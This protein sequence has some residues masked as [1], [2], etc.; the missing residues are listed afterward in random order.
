MSVIRLSFTITFLILALGWGFT[1]DRGYAG[2]IQTGYAEVDI[3]P[4]LGVTMPGYFTERRASDVLDP[5]L[6]KAMVMSDSET[7]LAIVALDLIGVPKDD[8]DRIHEKVK[9]KTGL[10]PHQVFIHS[11]HTHTGATVAEIMYQLPDK[12]A[13]AVDLALQ[14]RQAEMK[15]THG[16]QDEYSIAF[17]RR[18]LMKDGTVRT[19]PGRGNE[20]IVRPIGEIDPTVHTLSFVDT[21]TIIVSFGLH[22]DCIGGTKI[23]ADYP[24]HMTTKIKEILGGEWN[25]LFLNACCGNVN[26]INVNH[27]DQRSGYEE[28][29]R[30]G[31]T[32]AQ[33]AIRAHQ[34][35]RTIAVDGLAA[36]RKTVQCP[37]RKV[38]PEDYEWA[39]QMM[40]ADPEKASKR[41]FNEPTAFKIIALAESEEPSHPADILVFRIGPVGLVG[42]PA[43]V[44]V[45]VA[46]DIKTHSLL[47]PTLVIGITGGYMGYLP[48]PRGYDEGGYE[49]SYASARYDPVTPILWSDTA[50]QLI[51]ESIRN[52]EE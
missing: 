35:A 22:L 20:A 38:K 28:S 41:N 39:K 33:S 29:R 13:E 19:N 36:D 45:E 2:E 30:I 12:V 11:T 49:G 14:D 31:Y 5:L 27:P 46:R 18:Y 42:L 21:K 51:R 6:A 52:E 15:I 17:I 43:E 23:S 25:V 40:A 7:T 48:H 4:P 8:I 32:L 3:T 37:I 34:N 47:D 24:Y 44:F 16:V 9:E 10:E 1:G 26:H 50:T